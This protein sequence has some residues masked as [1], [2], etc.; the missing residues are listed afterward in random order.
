MD[1]QVGLTDEAIADLAGIVEFIAHDS[2]EA[3]ERVGLELLATAES[4]H[5]LPHRGA[6]VKGRS[7]MRK[8]FRWSYAIYYRIKPRERRVEVLRIWDARRDPLRL[9]LP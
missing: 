1:F 4:L 7:D 3:A 6:A 2:A 5:N 8:V 9:K